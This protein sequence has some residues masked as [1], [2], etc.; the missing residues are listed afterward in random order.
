MA[1]TTKNRLRFE[2]LES[3][4]MLAADIVTAVVTGNNLIITG[5]GNDDAFLVAGDGTPGDV[6]IT[7]K[8]SGLWNPT[9]IDGSQNG[10]PATGTPNGSITLTGVTGNITINLG[11][12]NTTVAVEDLTADNLSIAG[13]NG[14]DH[15][16]V[17]LANDF[18]EFGLPEI[19]STPPPTDN[20]VTLAGSLS[21]AIGNAEDLIAVCGSDAAGADTSIGGNLTISAGNG[22]FDQLSVGGG[23]AVGGNL[24]ITVG[25]GGNATISEGST[26]VSGNE[27][28]SAGT[29]D[30]D[31]VWFDSLDAFPSPPGLTA[32]SG[33]VHIGGNL[34]ISAEGGDDVLLEEDLVVA[35]D[36]SINLGSG[37]NTF[38]IGNPPNTVIDV[39]DY[40]YEGGPVSIGRNLTVQMGSGDSSF[41]AG[42][43]KVANDL[44]I[45]GAAGLDT[46]GNFAGAIQDVQNTAPV[47]PDHG[48]H[49]FAG[50]I[51]ATTVAPADDTV[52]LSDVTAA[53]A[54]IFT[55]VANTDT[56]NIQGSSFTDLGVGLG[57]GNGSLSIGTTTTTHST[58]LIGLGTSNTYDDLGDNRFANL[59]TQGLTPP[60]TATSPASPPLT[61]PIAKQQS[62]RHS[63][64]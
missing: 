7:G 17:G 51:A 62:A 59:Y 54:G 57:T 22:S 55:R 52:T 43:L 49:A 11:T 50:T 8:L 32:I 9:Q 56:V 46:S 12:G 35:L 53:E 63:W 47:N 5:D 26:A 10:T 58:T 16:D 40:A 13:G 29:G 15:V 60:P 20:A 19:G 41:Y 6:F 34:S 38:S 42:N 30:D 24:A 2:R 25:N 39:A 64:Q 45:T 3:R 18:F 36:E 37:V 23:V 1:R 44:F 48:D 33:S 31:T 4:T 21:I 28:V 14:F 61:T 27:T